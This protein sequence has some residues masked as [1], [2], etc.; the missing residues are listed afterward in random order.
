[1]EPAVLD[2]S[3]T[4]KSFRPT[5]RGKSLSELI[6]SLIANLNPPVSFERREHSRSALPFLMKFVPLDGQ[7]E[8]L[9]RAESVV[10]GKDVS[11]RGISF[12]HPQPIPCRRGL[13]TVDHPHAGRLT[14]EV[15]LQR[16]RFHRLGWYESGGRLVRA[17]EMVFPPATQ[18]S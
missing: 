6:R 17:V 4:M 3:L 5:R 10:V 1:M 14:V 16:C 11:E 15:E 2:S 8:P 7:G 18:A 9:Y 12:Y 13:L